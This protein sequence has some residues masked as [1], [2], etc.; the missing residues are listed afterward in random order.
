MPLVALLQYTVAAVALMAAVVAVAVGTGLTRHWTEL[1]QLA[2]YAIL[3]A[4][5]FMALTVQAFGLRAFIVAASS[6]ALGFEIAFRDLGCRRSSWPA[7]LFWWPL[8]P[9]PSLSSQ[10]WFDTVTS[11]SGGE[12]DRASKG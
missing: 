12:H 3:G 1:P 8:A 11:S 10:G 2:S 7:A 5:M 6:A 9:T 4:A